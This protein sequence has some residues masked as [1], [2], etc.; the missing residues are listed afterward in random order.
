MLVA[1]YMHNV[2]GEQYY[3]NMFGLNIIL[4][5]NINVIIF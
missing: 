1:F 3:K 4:L 2:G 5:Y